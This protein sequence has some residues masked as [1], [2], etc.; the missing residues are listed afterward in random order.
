MRGYQVEIDSSG[1]ETVF[2][3]APTSLANGDKVFNYNPRNLSEPG[4]GFIARV[5]P[6]FNLNVIDRAGGGIS[7]G[8]DTLASSNF[9]TIEWMEVQFSTG[10]DISF[11]DVDDVS[12]LNRSIWATGIA[13]NFDYSSGLSGA[14]S[15]LNVINSQ[16]DA[17]D[18]AFRHAFSP[19]MDV[20]SLLIG[21]A[22][23]FD[24]GAIEAQTFRSQFFI[25]GLGFEINDSDGGGDGGDPT[26]PVSAPGVLGLM[27]LGLVSLIGFVGRRQH[28]LS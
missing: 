12:N 28:R 10:V 8:F 3:P 18:G 27:V 24:L 4:V 16:D 21:S 6:D 14:I 25:T 2:G 5:A 22:P 1:N 17:T 7:P 13:G 11:I 15:G 20:T 9:E 26:T 19:M 23:N